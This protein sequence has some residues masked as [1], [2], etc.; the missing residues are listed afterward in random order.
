M[1]QGICFVHTSRPAQAVKSGDD[2]ETNGD[3][4]GRYRDDEEDKDRAIHVIV[5]TGKSDERKR[6]SGK[7]NFQTHV[8]NN[9][10]TPH[11]H[12]RQPN[13]KKQTSK[14][15]IVVKTNRGHEGKDAENKAHLSSHKCS[16]AVYGAGSA[17]RAPARRL[18]R[19]LD[20][21]PKGAT[22]T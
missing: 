9:G 11:Q 20:L 15:D 6:G 5:K 14:R 1:P 3:F 17:A 21:R 7:H 4:G 12:P 10:V 22:L 8:Y 18:R 16:R 2:R 19:E 13:G